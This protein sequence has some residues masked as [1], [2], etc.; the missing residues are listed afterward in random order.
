MEKFNV[1]NISNQNRQFEL[2]GSNVNTSINFQHSNNLKI[3]GEILTEWRNKIHNHQ[4]K[5]SKDAHNNTLHQTCLPINTISNERKIDP[6]SLQPLSLNFWRTNQTFSEI[7][8]HAKKN[9]KKLRVKL[10]IDPTGT[11]IHLGHSILF[12]K[13]RAFQD[14]GHIAVLIIGDFTA[15]IGDPT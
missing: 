10:G 9:N 1:N 14:N 7:I 8:D 13:L 4:F 3:K 5:I 11:D 15:Q 6:F 12:K 2:F